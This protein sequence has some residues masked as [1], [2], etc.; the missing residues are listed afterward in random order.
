MPREV[1]LRFPPSAEPTAAGDPRLLAAAAARELGLDPGALAEVRPRR[2]SFDA[3]PRHRDWR[4]AADV[5]LQG[6]PVPPGPATEPPTF[7]RPGPGAPHVAVVGSGPAGTFCA[8]DLLAAGVRV[9]VLERGADVRGR[10]R[11][12]A[13]LNRGRGVDPDCNYCFGEG[14]AG[15]FSDGKL[16]TRSG[17]KRAVR[18]VLETLV[19]HGAPPEILASWRPHVGSNRLP[20]VVVAP[21][22][23]THL[24]LPTIYSV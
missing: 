18:G 21:V 16:Y 17:N 8:L 23:Y 11:A 7:P 22:S 10:R 4:V 20:R 13:E 5:W 3:R 9:T 1:V 19:A 6:E 12:L 24:T 2:I 14:G 15:T